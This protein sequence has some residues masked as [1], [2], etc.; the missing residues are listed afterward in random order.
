[1]SGGLNRRYTQRRRSSGV[2]VDPLTDLL[3]P[4]GI[5]PPGQVLLT[6][7]LGGYVI[8]PQEIGAVIRPCED[9]VTPQSVVAQ[10]EN[11]R[12]R[13][14]VGKDDVRKVL[15]IVERLNYPD[16]GWC[17]IRYS[18]DLQMFGDLRPGS[19]YGVH[20]VPGKLVEIKTAPTAKT[21]V[22]C[23]VAAS[24]TTLLVRIS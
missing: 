22:S 21:R 15:G 14:A 10:G 5:A 2:V 20:K 19:I 23:G 11:G 9:D 16:T 3:Q 1:M 17:L 4:G 7:G 12:A 6:D 8:G 18:G 24:S 13:L